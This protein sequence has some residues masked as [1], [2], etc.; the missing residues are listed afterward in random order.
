MHHFDYQNGVM[1]AEDVPLTDIAAQVGTPFYCY[2]HATIARHYQVFRE[3][4]AAGDTLVAYSIKA[5]SNLAVVKTLA[6]L[7]SGADVVS[8]GELRRALA[9]GIPANKIVFSG[10]GKTR[11]EMK[12]ALEAGIYQFNVESEPELEALNEV[13]VG[14]NI[15]APIT[16]RV[17]PDV[18]AETHAKITTGTSENKF[19]IPWQRARAVYARAGE[20]PGIDVV[21]LDMHIGSQITKLAPFEAA[22]AKAVELVKSLRSDGHAISRLDLGGGLGIPYES[23]NELPPHPD[24]YARLIQDLTA[25]LGV[26]LIFEPGRV[27][28]G[29]AGILVSRVVYAKHGEA[30]NFLIL[31]AAMNDLIRPALYDAHHD[32][33]PVQKPAETATKSPFDV[34]GPVCETGDT[35]ARHRDLPDL[36]EGDLVA[37][38]SAGAYGAVQAGEYNTRPRIPEV[39]VKGRDM[40]VIHDRPTYEDMLARDKLAPWQT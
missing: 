29:N 40:A 23:G 37:I 38:M 33:L 13:A 10:V 8:E 9:A 31:D 39:L 3:A 27:I 28:M 26:Q 25:D 1:H 18:D 4:F 14:L 20:L 30:R 6:D 15:Q 34:V 32:I 2:T 21:G 19:G 5:N 11:Q 35:F 16:L 24:E 7:G 17:N 12:A 22:F 36:A